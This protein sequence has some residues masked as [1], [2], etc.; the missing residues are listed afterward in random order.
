MEPTPTRKALPAPPRCSRR[1][2]T[3]TRLRL[4]CVGGRIGGGRGRTCLRARDVARDLHATDKISSRT[5]WRRICAG[6]GRSKKNA[7]VASTT[8]LRSSSHVFPS[9]KMFSVRRPAQ[10][11]PSAS[12]T[13]SK[14]NS[15]IAT[16]YGRDLAESGRAPLL[17]T[18]RRRRIEP[19]GPPHGRVRGGQRHYE[20]EQH[21]GDVHPWRPR[22]R[23]A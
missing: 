2:S 11:P 12:C 4:G 21:H 8:F 22:Y 20:K 17:A 18:Q 3:S 1:N 5:R 13:T 15:A 7:L 19:A 14:T 9:V 23:G 6:R 10:Y 16:S